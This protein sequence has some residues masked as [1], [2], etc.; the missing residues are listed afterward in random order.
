MKLEGKMVGPWVQECRQAWLA[1]APSLPPRTLA[2]DLR[3]ITFVD[4]GGTELLREIYKRTHAKMLTDS[5]LTQHFAEQAMRNI[6]NG[7]KGA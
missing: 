2:L 4:A 6:G 7:S 3:G 5:P 1:L